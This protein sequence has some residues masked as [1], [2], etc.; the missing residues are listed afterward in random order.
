[1]ERLSDFRWVDMRVS[2]W[3]V[4]CRSREPAHFVAVV[5][6]LQRAPISSAA[7]LSQASSRRSTCVQSRFRS[8]FTF[9]RS[10]RLTWSCFGTVGQLRTPVL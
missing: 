8:P 3:W 10:S 1:M 9:S 4:P 5:A 2:G 7:I 6:D